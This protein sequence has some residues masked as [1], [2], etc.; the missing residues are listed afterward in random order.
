MPGALYTIKSTEGAPSLKQAAKMLGVEESVLDE[1]FG[2]TLIDPR[3]QLYTVKVKDEHAAKV[4]AQRGSEGG[5][6]SNP[7]ISDFGPPQ[8]KR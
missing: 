7:I 8:K 6:F 1:H 4:A 3:Q 2:V 5:E